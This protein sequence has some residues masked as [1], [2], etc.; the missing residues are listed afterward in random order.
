MIIEA[1]ISKREEDIFERGNFASHIADLLTL[2]ENSPSFVLALEGK[3]GMG[4]TSTVNLIK[5]SLKQNSTDVVV[6]D[7]NPWL[8][9]SLDSVIEGFLVQLASSVNQTLNTEVASKAA[10]KIL[11]FAKFLSPIKLIPGVEPWG[12]LVEK[13][14]N[15]VGA[16]TQAAVDMSNLDLNRR[17][18]AVQKSIEDI[19]KPIIVII[20]DIDRLPPD[21]IRIVIQVVKAIGDFNRVSYLL[22]FD[23]DPVIK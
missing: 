11:K 8:I 2:K 1:P 22:A 16:S 4:K 15:T 9:G 7:F 18:E 19:G 5:E 10:A 14:L 3:W 20:D 23:P 12:T 17:K 21:E 13:V 6:V